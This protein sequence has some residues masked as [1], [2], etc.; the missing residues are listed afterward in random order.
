MMWYHRVMKKETR[1]MIIFWMAIASSSLSIIAF[2]TLVAGEAYVRYTLN[3][4]FAFLGGFGLSALAFL[5][6]GQVV[7]LAY[8]YRLER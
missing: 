7:S 8:L 5:V 3:Q 2:F 6:L 4:N 1:E